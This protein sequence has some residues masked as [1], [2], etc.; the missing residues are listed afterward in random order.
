LLSF[1]LSDL[2]G[3]P[4]GTIPAAAN[5]RF[6]SAESSDATTDMNAIVLT[7]ANEYAGPITLVTDRDAG[8]AGRQVQV[9][10]EV[11]VPVGTPAGSY[12]A[13]YGFKS[14]QLVDE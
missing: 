12:S 1:K 5:V 2:L 7:S 4:T 13:S 3:N 8:R 6:Y 10:V 9:V 11:K 14:E